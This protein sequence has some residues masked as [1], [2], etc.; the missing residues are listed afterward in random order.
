ME[1][2]VG[3]KVRVRE[4][5]PEEFER[6]KGDD[7][8]YEV[9]RI[10]H[11]KVI[12][13]H[14]LAA[15]VYGFTLSIPT[16]HLVKVEEEKKEA[17]FKVGDKVC[18]LHS[19]IL[20]GVYTIIG[21]E[22]REKLGW[23]YQLNIHEWYPSID[24]APYTEPTGEAINPGD[25][26]R[27]KSDGRIVTVDGIGAKSGDI[28]FYVDGERHWVRSDEA[29]LIDKPT[30][31][32]NLQDATASELRDLANHGVSV[33]DEVKRRNKIREFIETHPF[34]IESLKRGRKVFEDMYWDSYAADLAK[35]IAIVYAKQKRD[36]RLAVRAAKSVVEELKGK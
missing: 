27:I 10:N 11:S 24:L 23:Y 13:Q 25:K 20:R 15:G 2:K 31:D 16:K 14:R 21:A 32:A 5:A 29:E 3:D 33:G 19:E 6:F 8:N 1:I 36:V 18:V 22:C 30:E 34:D 4:G 17:K 9:V 28:Y 12:I 35:E 26:V 7:I